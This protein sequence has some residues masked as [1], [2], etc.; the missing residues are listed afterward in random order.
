[1]LLIAVGF[2][3]VLVHFLLY[4]TFVRRS[5]SANPEEAILRF[6]I[7]SFLSVLLASAAYVISA[8]ESENVA[9]LFA[10]LAL[11]AIYSMTFLEVWSVT[12]GSFVFWTLSRI[13][14]AQGRPLDL[15]TLEEV[16]TAK[17]AKRLQDLASLGL[18][19]RAQDGAW[20]LTRSGRLAHVVIEL[21]AFVTN[22]RRSG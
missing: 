12:Q 11:H 8:P 4:V 15:R 10:A 21:I 13:D 22:I 3:W 16:G 5:Y 6:H 1:M 2:S 19:H 17:R 20:R 18:V 14:A 7:F 9:G